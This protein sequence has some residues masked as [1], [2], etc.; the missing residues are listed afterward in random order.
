MN[1]VD[2]EP[3]FEGRLGVRSPLVIPVFAKK[4]VFL[5]NESRIQKRIITYQPCFLMIFFGKNWITSEGHHLKGFWIA[6]K[7]AL[8]ALFQKSIYTIVRPGQEH[9]ENNFWNCLV[10]VSKKNYKKTWLVCYYS[11]FVFDYSSQKN[12]VFVNK[13]ITRANE[14]P[15]FLQNL[16]QS[17][18]CSPTRIY[19]TIVLSPFKYCLVP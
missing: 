8:N 12:V 6:E 10:D 16:V 4:H 19:Y 14:R 9:G 7:K 13:G 3:D 17:L 2:F 11:F 1:I 18:R 5:R 15:I